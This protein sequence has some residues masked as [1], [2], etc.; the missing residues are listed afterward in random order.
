MSNSQIVIDFNNIKWMKENSESKSINADELSVVCLPGSIWGGFG[1]E[2]PAQNIGYL[3]RS[4]LD[5]GALVEGASSEVVISLD[6]SLAPSAFGEQA[7]L[8]LFFGDAADLTSRWIKL[9]LEG[10]KNSAPPAIVFAHQLSLDSPSVLHKATLEPQSP[11]VNLLLAIS[12]HEDRLK[13][14]DRNHHFH[15]ELDAPSSSMHL[16]L[17]AHGGPAID[18]QTA[19]FHSFQIHF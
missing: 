17:I 7:G 19:S 16:G 3:D 9:V 11:R 2:N 12:K 13:I 10:M 4:T 8:C 14:E 15:F 5:L 18:P 1:R 6:L